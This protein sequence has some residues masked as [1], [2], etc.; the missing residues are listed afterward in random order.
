MRFPHRAL[1]ASIGALLVV[2]AACGSITDPPKVLQSPL[3]GQWLLETHSDTFSFVTRGP[4][5]QDCPN[6]FDY[7]EHKRTTVDGA[8]LGGMMQLRDSGL[9][10]VMAT[11]V[12]A[13]GTLAQRFCDSVDDYGLT[14]CTHVG[15]TTTGSY[16]GAISGKPDSTTMQTLWIDIR[17]TA[18]ADREFR[19]QATYAG[20]SIYGR[21]VWGSMGHGPRYYGT[22]VMRRVK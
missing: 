15:S 20:D 19:T 4:D 14:G 22:M 10:G 9:N 8:Y 16:A 17:D 1:L 3:V 5:A 12:Q 13:T 21:F 18:A 7:C 6:Y 2:V 11:S